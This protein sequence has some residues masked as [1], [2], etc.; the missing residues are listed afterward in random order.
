[1]CGP[2]FSSL[3]AH[4]LNKK[5]IESVPAHDLL[6]GVDFS[7]L[8]HLRLL[9]G[10]T[11]INKTFY[12]V[13]EAVISSGHPE[14]IEI[15]FATNGTKSPSEKLI[16]LLRKFRRV[17]IDFSVDGVGPLGEFIRPGA[18]WAQVSNNIVKW[19]AVARQ[20]QNL[21]HLNMHTT[22]QA[23]NF[24]GLIDII[25]FCIENR[26]TWSQRL[27]SS[28]E[29]LTLDRV[30]LANRQSIVR[31]FLLDS[32]VEKIKSYFESRNEQTIWD[33]LT[34]QACQIPSRSPYPLISFLNSIDSRW[35]TSWPSV[36]PWITPEVT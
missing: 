22:I 10:E 1:M 16:E 24:G 34:V 35:Q 20:S 29:H 2:E 32:R 19:Q 7:S 5:T 11:L 9:G 8:T 6:Q 28:P 21:W 17:N 33:F 3:W 25:D 12:D 18:S 4:E 31:N 30:S 13:L 14:M 27:L 23:L 15:S 26:L 36:V